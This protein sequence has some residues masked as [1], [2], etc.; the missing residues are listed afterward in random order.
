[1]ENT[2]SAVIKSVLLVVF[3]A[4]V[5]LGLF[6]LFTRNH[7]SSNEENYTLTVVDQI[8]TTNLEKDYP[9]N[10]RKV[11]EM[12]ANIMKVLYKET[13]TDDQQKKM[14]EVLEG[15]MDDELLA[16]Q[17]NFYQS[18]KNEVKTRRDEDYSIP[19]YQ[20]QSREPEVVT[21]EGR[22]MCN[23]DCYLSLRKGTSSQG[24]YY[25]FILR[26]DDSG[27]WKILGWTQK[28]N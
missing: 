21:V 9:A 16:N 8:T 27:K 28:A 11:V 1:M 14:L 12:Y 20:V 7:R 25:M 3:G 15:L 4:L 2:K 24:L 26:Q 19:T 23:V 17:S 5:V 6:L 22:K 18:M 13:Y 10:P